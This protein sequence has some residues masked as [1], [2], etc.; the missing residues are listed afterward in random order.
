MKVGDDV[1]LEGAPEYGV[2]KIVRFHASQGTALVDFKDKDDL[3]YCD[4]NAL[5]KSVEE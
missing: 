3:T 2:G 4:Y 1:R 5:V